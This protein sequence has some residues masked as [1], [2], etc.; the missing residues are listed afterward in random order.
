L[1]FVCTGIDVLAMLYLLQWLSSIKWDET[2][3][4]DNCHLGCCAV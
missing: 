3:V 4:K 2:V 1:V